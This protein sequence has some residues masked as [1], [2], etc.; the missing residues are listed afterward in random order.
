MNHA[1]QIL[2]HIAKAREAE[3]NV[4]RPP[5]TR[6]N[7][8]I[9]VVTILD[10]KITVHHETHPD[11]VFDRD[12]RDRLKADTQFVASARTNLPKCWEALEVLVKAMKIQADGV[13]PIECEPLSEPFA[14]DQWLVNQAEKALS[15]VNAI[16]LP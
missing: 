8:D 9:N 12:V 10:G 1:N 15:K 3:K 13:V 7:L 11:D 6:K 14:T 16:L 2:A 5:W 4:T